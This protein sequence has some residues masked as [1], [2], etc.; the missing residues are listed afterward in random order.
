MK[1]LIPLLIILPLL[2]MGCEKKEDVR[3]KIKRA[4]LSTVQYTIKKLIR[5]TDKSWQ[6][7]GD[8]KILF[9]CK[10]TVKVGIDMGKLSSNDIEIKGNDI[11]L[12]LPAPEIMS[13]N[14]QPDDI[15]VA[16]THVT[17]L[18]SNYSNKERERILTFGEQ[19]IRQDTLLTGTMMREAEENARNFFEIML[20]QNGFKTINVNFKQQ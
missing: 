18:R 13:F 5:N 3:Y 6:V 1:K 15:K 11:S 9:S 2:L 10:A 12:T 14:M 17:G 20:I 4:Q 8:K 16:Y 7:L 19:E